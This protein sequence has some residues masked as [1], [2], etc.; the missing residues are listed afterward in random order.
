[1]KTRG[2]TKSTTWPLFAAA[3][4][5]YPKAEATKIKNMERMRTASARQGAVKLAHR[6]YEEQRDVVYGAMVDAVVRWAL[7]DEA[8]Q[9]EANAHRAGRSVSALKREREEARG[10]FVRAASM[11]HEAGIARR[12]GRLSPSGRIRFRQDDPRAKRKPDPKPAKPAKRPRSLH[13]MPYR[14][15]VDLL[16]KRQTKRAAAAE[17]KPRKPTKKAR[18]RHSGSDAMASIRALARSL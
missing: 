9:K 4:V 12:E 17:A 8:S 18:A 14:E 3:E 13:N 1:M 10:R 6:L 2:I 7:Y 5:C 11:A 16:E 15:Y